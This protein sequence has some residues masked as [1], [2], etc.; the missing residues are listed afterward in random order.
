MHAVTDVN[1]L[2]CKSVV[3]TLLVLLLEEGGRS[4]GVLRARA[5][6]LLLE[7]RA[8]MAVWVRQERLVS[9]A[10]PRKRLVGDQPT[11]ASLGAMS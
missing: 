10:W 2:N 5:W 3:L 6:S 8:D 9:L 7:D 11:H 4:E 1:S